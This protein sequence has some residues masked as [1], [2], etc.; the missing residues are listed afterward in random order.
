MSSQTR[1]RVG[2]LLATALAVV[3]VA[4][5]NGQKER[6]DPL[7]VF[8]FQVEVP[9]LTGFFRSVSGLSVETEVVDYQ[10]GGVNDVVRKLPGRTKFANIRLSRAFTG[11]RSLYEFYERNRKPEP[12]R[13]VGRIVMYDRHGT[14]LAAWQFNNAFP[15]KWEGP[16]FDASKNELAIETIEIAHEGL[17][18]E[19]GEPP[20]PPPPPQ[21]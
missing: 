11:D 8:Y 20:P 5:V 9:G 19:S 17:T 14:L 1:A 13:F 6:R 3:A 21:K 10:E 4:V 12:D 7:P 15:A 2:G 16:D 18:Y